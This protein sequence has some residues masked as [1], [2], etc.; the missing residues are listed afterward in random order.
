[1]GLE[2][3]FPKAK[4]IFIT[5]TDTGVG[6]TLVAG[7]IARFLS[8]RGLRVGVFK[9]VASGCRREREGLVSSD[10]EFLAYCSESE[11]SLSV[12]NPVRFAVP[13]APIVCEEYENRK[14]DFEEMA[15]SYKYICQESDVV[16]V[17]GIGGALVPVTE[18]FT[19]LDIAAEMALP[20]V[21]VARPDL[22]TINHTLMT[23][24]CIRAAGLT[25]AGVV[26][27]GYKAD[28]ADIAEE[29]APRIISGFGQ[30]NLLCV[31]PFD[32]DSD[33]EEGLLGELTVESLGDCDWERLCGA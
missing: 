10:A 33:V 17:E 15:T 25:V 4:G 30:T 14:F 11:F 29:S 16:I 2:L 28:G 12:I 32:E 3:D 23:L 24:A 6:K 22:G 19:I 8:L 21:V 26:I 5:G 27:N 1:M 31:V 9:P 13:A 7:G 20:V 18:D